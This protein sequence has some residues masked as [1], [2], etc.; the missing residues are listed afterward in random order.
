M[1]YIILLAVLLLSI[2]V[3]ALPRVVARDGPFDTV[4]ALVDETGKPIK[5]LTET[6]NGILSQFQPPKPEPKP[7][8]KPE[9]KPA[10]K[11]DPKPEPESNTE[12]RVPHGI[13][14]S[15]YNADGTCKTQSQVNADIARIQPSYAFVRIYG[16][17]CDQAHTVTAA[18]RKHNMQ[19]FAGVYDLQDYPNSLHTI[20]DAASGD[21][22]TIHTISIGN[23]L[24]N[25]GS[26]SPQ[27]M[28]QALQQARDTLRPAGYTGPIV[29]V[30]TFSMLLAHP[31]LCEASDYCAANCH[32]FFDAT[33]SAAGAGAYVAGKADEISRKAGGK[34]VV[35]TESGWPHAGQPNGK[36]VPSVENNRAAVGSLRESFRGNPADL[37]LFSAFDDAWKKDS[38]GTFGAERFWGIYQ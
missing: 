22:S 23:E 29:T 20:I 14:Y 28:V 16:V 15:P 10:P 34:R 2:H 9:P 31:Q 25:R 24:V 13:S 7:E 30:D 4:I 37:I 6:A 33:Q 18:A 26:A 38:E 27:Q 8:H 35:I 19:V 32:A 5:Y 21:W 11:P 36:A 3:A 17:D 12:A 1:K